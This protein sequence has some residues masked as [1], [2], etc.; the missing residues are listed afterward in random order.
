MWL[1][2]WTSSAVYADEEHQ[3]S[4][5]KSKK[6][7]LYR[8]QRPTMFQCKSH[9][10]PQPKGKEKND[11]MA[12]LACQRN[13]GRDFDPA[14]DRLITRGGYFLY[15]QPCWVIIDNGPTDATS[16]TTAWFKWSSQKQDLHEIPGPLHA[17]ILQLFRER[18]DF[19]PAK[20]PHYIGV[21]DEEFKKKHGIEAYNTL[22]TD[23]QGK[24][25]VAKQFGCIIDSNKS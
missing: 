2:C 11:Y 8:G 13:W 24:M 1:H 25:E 17:K 20:R 21:T 22:V 19:D 15:N 23:R 9:E 3:R 18:Y 14:Q 6:L 12:N 5:I 10:M 4:L 7:P 16:Y